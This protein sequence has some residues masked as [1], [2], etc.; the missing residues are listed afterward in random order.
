[1]K[2]FHLA[3]DALHVHSKPSASH[4]WAIPQ[5]AQPANRLS[6][7]SKQHR[8]AVW[9]ARN[10]ISFAKKFQDMENPCDLT[11]KGSPR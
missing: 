6:T 8:H 2:G 5:F 7:R 9:M 1:M 10:P 4:P 11:P 3:G